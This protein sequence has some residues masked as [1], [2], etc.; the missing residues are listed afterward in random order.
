MDEQTNPLEEQL[1]KDIAETIVRA[2]YVKRHRTEVVFHISEEPW[3]TIRWHIRKYDI[4][5]KHVR[6]TPPPCTT[7][8]TWF[9]KRDAS[10]SNAKELSAVVQAIL[11]GVLS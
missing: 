2:G 11:N 7:T 1:R 9:S 6:D 3:E 10:F 8:E 5:R 4:T